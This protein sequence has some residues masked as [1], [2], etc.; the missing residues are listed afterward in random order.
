[1]KALGQ[2]EGEWNMKI[3]MFGLGCSAETVEKKIR[4]E[5]KIIGYTDSRA[6]IGLYK[7]LPFYQLS[8]LKNITYDFIVITTKNHKVAIELREMLV[9][10]Y[11]IRYET[12]IP[13]ILYCD[14][15]IYKIKRDKYTG[16]QCMI[17]G[18][19]HARD[20]I[21]ADY[22]P[23]PSVNLATSSQDIYFN[24]RIFELCLAEHK[25]ALSQLKYIIFDLYDY[26]I[27]NIDVS[28]TEDFFNYLASG[29]VLEA[30][31][32]E[33]SKQCKKG[34]EKDVFDR[35]YFLTSKSDSIERIMQALFYDT[36]SKLDE[37]IEESYC[38]TKVIHKMEPLAT[39]KCFGG[40]VTKRYEE[41]IYENRII[42]ENFCQNVS[43]LDSNIQI[44]FTLLPRYITME[45]IME[46]IMCK[47]REEFEAIVG[48]LCD[49]YNAKLLN[50]KNRKDISENP[51]FYWDI[52]HLNTAGGISMTSL[53]ESKLEW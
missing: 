5:H 7:G 17:L 18:N 9:S 6:K 37:S 3:I 39:E 40:V 35:L 47:W 24:T 36:G 16:L 48:M 20:G 14:T 45:R 52:N 44:I 34:F 33:K 15:E 1:M 32:Y 19:S 41:T 46:P 21:L 25:D 11:G 30:H 8:E 22:L 49:K 29:G 31:N 42:L 12:I 10:L 43:R 51:Y 23:M 28:A 50:M 2:P 53:L 38:R 13:F 26:N 4:K 27:F